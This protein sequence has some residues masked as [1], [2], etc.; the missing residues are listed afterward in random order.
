MYIN[1]TL[2]AREITGSINIS[3]RTETTISIL[4]S[5]LSF[6]MDSNVAEC[7]NES[8]NTH[9]HEWNHYTC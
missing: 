3:M 8:V 5:D 1:L 9:W 2:Y 4:Y 7:K 6:D